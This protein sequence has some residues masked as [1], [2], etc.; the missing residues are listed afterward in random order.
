MTTSPEA[1]RIT[2]ADSPDSYQVTIDLAAHTRGLQ[3]G[4]N[5]VDRV[6]RV[7]DP[8]TNDLREVELIDEGS[9]RWRELAGVC[10][11]RIGLGAGSDP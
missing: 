11:S 1:C 2:R 3:D 8:G 4:S 5:K 10:R 6:I 9:V 7:T